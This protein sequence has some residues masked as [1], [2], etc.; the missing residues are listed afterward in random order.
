MKPPKWL[1]QEMI[2]DFIDSYQFEEFSNLPK[3][4][5]SQKYLDAKEELLNSVENRSRA[6]IKVLTATVIISIITLPICIKYMSK[7][8]VRALKRR[9]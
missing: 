5:F 7:F 2:D 4:E 9:S 3:P 1:P 8:I 6:R